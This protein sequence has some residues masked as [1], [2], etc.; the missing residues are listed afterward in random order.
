[1]ILSTGRICAAVLSAAVFVSTI[2]AAFAA[3]LSPRHTY[4]AKEMLFEKISHPNTNVEKADGI[5]DYI[6]GGS[7]APYVSGVSKEGQGD[8][9]QSYSYASASYGDWLYI[10][11]MYGGLSAAGILGLSLGELSPAMIN[12]MYNGNMYTGE[13]DGQYAG[14]VLLKYNVKTGETKLLM[15][16]DTNGIMPTF[17]DAIRFNDKLYFV[18]MV[19]DMQSGLTQAEITQAIMMQN[20]F[21]CIY[22]IDPANGDKMTRIYNCVDIAGYKELVQDNV[23]PST[24]AIGT[25]KNALIAGTLDTHGAHLVASKNPSAGQ[26]AFSVIADMDDLFNY[27]KIHRQDANGGGGIYQVIE[28]NDD[29]YVVVCAGDVASRNPETGTL[30]GFAIIKG[31]CSGDP[32]RKSS[33]K[34]SVLAGDQKDGAKYP[35]ALDEERVSAVACTLEVFDDYLYI[36]DY[37]DTSS[38]LQGFVLN[39][40]YKTLGTNLEQSI[41]L[42][43]MDKNERIEKVVGDPTTRFPKSLTGLGSGYGTHMNQYTWQSTVYNDKLYVSTLDLSTFL[44]PLVV[45]TNG[46]L[47]KMDKDEWKSQINYLRVLAELLF[48]DDSST[49]DETVGKAARAAAAKATGRANTPALELTDE[50]VSSLKGMAKRRGARPSMNVMTKLFEINDRLDKLAGSFDAANIE[51]FQKEYSALVA[52]YAQI[53]DLL[54]ENV[55][56]MYDLILNVATEDNLRSIIGSLQYMTDAKPGFDL[57]EISHTDD[58]VKVRAVIQDGM[59]DRYNHGLRIFEEMEDYWVFGT[60]NPFYGTQ[61]WRTKNVAPVIDE[62]TEGSQETVTQDQIDDLPQTGDSSSLIAWFALAA[63]SC[64][65]L[66]FIQRKK[67]HAA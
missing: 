40:N 14:G 27:P 60:A 24:R 32:T 58:G 19:L 43:R 37:N 49:D 67:R 54:P 17:R 9:G 44:R 29:L 34:W 51:S 59:G 25:Y 4:R 38:A 61:L 23:F 13:P 41:N 1:M 2:P 22:E 3:E 57:Y 30:R 15:S 52:D 47:L 28:Y 46:D 36:G 8:R 63:A 45:M 12:A 39:S 48:A 31:E 20:G 62:E 21:P 42:Y 56:K 16:R 35:F 10:G 50:Q 7:I 26:K 66:A 65:A 64:C 18:G 33:W 55:K 53:S 11:T 6:G 5:V